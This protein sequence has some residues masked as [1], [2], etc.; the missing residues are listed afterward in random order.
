MYS[1]VLL[2]L[3][4]LLGILT[5][6]FLLACLLQKLDELNPHYDFE[7]DEPTTENQNTELEEN[8]NQ[9]TK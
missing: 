3:S 2:V 6:S 1:S 5:V 4:F 9:E 7:I 8:D